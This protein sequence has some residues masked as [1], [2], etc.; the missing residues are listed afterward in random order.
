MYQTDVATGTNLGTSVVTLPALLH[1]PAATLAT[2]WKILYDTG[3]VPV[4][5]LAMSS[6]AGFAVLAYQSTVAPASASSLARR[7]LYIGAAVAAFGLAPYTRLLMWQNITA[8]EKRA[9]D[10]AEGHEQS[11]T[12]QLVTA[13]GKL[14]LWR[15]VMLLSS[16]GLGVWASVN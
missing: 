1:A 3:V 2:Q 10:A 8:L 16:A 13:W 9:K 12:H 5:S 11:D 6:A 15:G 7:K 4:V 14:N